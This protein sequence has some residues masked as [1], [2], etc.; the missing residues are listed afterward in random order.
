MELLTPD[1]VITG[2][3]REVI[4]GGAVLVDG[5]SIVAVGSLS[6][7]RSRPE[8]ARA[9][10][11]DLSGQTLL[12]GLIDCHVHL[13]FDASEAPVAHM[14]AASDH[15]LLV[16][17]LRN[18]RRLLAA[19]VTTARE[20]GARSLLD[21]VVQ[22]AIEEGKA[23]GPRLI[24]SN[25]PIT[26]TG[27]HC[28][29]M[30][31]E[32][33][34]HDGL[35]RA[36]REHHKAGA[37]V[38]KVMAT[39]GFMTAGSAPWYAQF[40]PDELR[41]I[42]DEAR[43]VGKRVAAHAHGLTG[44]RNSVAAGVDTIEHCSWASESGENFDDEVA[45]A[46][47]E[48]GIFVCPT[49]NVHLL[50][51][52]RVN[53]GGHEIPPGLIEGRKDRIARMRQMGVRLVAGT[54]A[55]ITLVEHGAYA[56]GLEGLAATG[57]PA[58]EVIECATSRAAQACGLDAITGTVEPG[59]DADLVAVPGNPVTDLSV[60]HNPAMVMTRGRVYDPAAV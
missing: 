23:P 58:E 32:R 9:I 5:S 1:R 28:W 17:M 42:V 38:I 37:Q 51:P 25:Q 49:A 12:P 26:V 44:I 10:V 14:L 31:C 50:R 21:L 33:D 8:A 43:R 20:L 53:L 15:Q 34:D 16:E 11:R 57:M 39:G 55:G 40:G 13:G 27:G 46:I 35:R 36:V 24:V 3:G 52:R 18:A 48:K 6:E 19:G 56:C 7:V 30:G 54:D 41:V 22:E 47:A 59:K 2:T 29:F 45:A 4:E 60:L